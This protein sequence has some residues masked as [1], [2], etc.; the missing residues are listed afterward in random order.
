LVGAY[1]QKWHLSTQG[2][3]TEVVA[4]W[5]AHLPHQLPL[6]HPS[7]RNRAWIKKNPWF[8]ADLLPELQRRVKELMR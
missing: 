6:P 7:W 1:A 2:S 5:R 4:R 8:E 3:V